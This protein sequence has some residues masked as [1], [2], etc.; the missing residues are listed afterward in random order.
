MVTNLLYDARD[1]TTINPLSLR[2]FRIVSPHPRKMSRD[3][4]TANDS[5]YPHSFLNNDIILR[6]VLQF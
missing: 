3:S 4:H 5:G 2:E 1:S 6:K